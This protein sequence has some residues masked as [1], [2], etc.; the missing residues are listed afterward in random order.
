MKVTKQKKQERYGSGHRYIY[1][2]KNLCDSRSNDRL[3]TQTF[4]T[5]NEISITYFFFPV[6]WTAPPMTVWLLL[7]RNEGAHQKQPPPTHN[8]FVCGGG[9]IFFHAGMKC[10]IYK[11]SRISLP[12]YLYLSLPLAPEESKC[13]L[14]FEMLFFS[15]QMLP[16]ACCTFSFESVEQ[17]GWWMFTAFKTATIRPPRFS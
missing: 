16:V 8:L 15:H 13:D 6:F 10:M 4:F 9:T 12:I 2:L 3:I 5:G 1:F 7:S 14:T 11:K 17:L